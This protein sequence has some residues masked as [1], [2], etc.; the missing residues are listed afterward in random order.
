MSLCIEVFIIG[1]ITQL[2]FDD[3]YSMFN[4]V[5]TDMSILAGNEYFNFIAAA[6]TK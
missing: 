1:R 5:F 2:L 3:L 4:T 6:S